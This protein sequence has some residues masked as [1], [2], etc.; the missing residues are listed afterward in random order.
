MPNLQRL[1]VVCVPGDDRDLDIALIN[2]KTVREVGRYL[3]HWVK[4]EEASVFNQVEDIR[5]KIWAK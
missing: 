4:K 1:S 5:K 2:P 3:L